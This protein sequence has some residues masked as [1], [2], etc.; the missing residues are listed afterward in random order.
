M[1]DGPEQ[2]TLLTEGP[3]QSIAWF[4]VPAGDAGFS[5][6]VLAVGNP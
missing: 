2:G 3:G 5:P 4:W 1:R 6:A